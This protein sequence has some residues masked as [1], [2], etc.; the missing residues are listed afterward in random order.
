MSQA[1]R[2]LNI[3][4]WGNTMLFVA[5]FTVRVGTPLFI[6]RID[7]NFGVNSEN[8]EE[9]Y[10]DANIN[11]EQVY[12]PYELVDA[13]LTFRDSRALYQDYFVV[14]PKNQLSH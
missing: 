3:V 7:Q 12:I 6:G 14:I 9:V 11:A 4:K 10:C 2:D 13:Y 8:G 1:E 5:S